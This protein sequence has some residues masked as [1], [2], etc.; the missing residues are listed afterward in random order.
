MLA[1][2]F[3]VSESELA[4]HYW[5]AMQWARQISAESCLQ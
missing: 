4:E 5:E 2:Q 1:Q 3:R